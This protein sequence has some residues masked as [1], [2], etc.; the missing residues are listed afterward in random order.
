[1]FTR[2]NRP[3]HFDSVDG[4][5]VDLVFLLLIPPAAAGPRVL[6]LQEGGSFGALGRS[7]PI[8]NRPYQGRPDSL[9]VLEPRRDVDG[10][11][12]SNEA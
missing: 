11:G 10:R 6:R 3:I 9:G 1:M 7:H 2:L 8:E 4:N 12:E 5:P